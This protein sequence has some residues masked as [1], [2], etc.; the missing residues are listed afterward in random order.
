VADWYAYGFILQAG[1]ITWH[2][3]IQNRFTL[4]ASCRLRINIGSVLLFI[5]LLFYPFIAFISGRSWMQFEMFAL[6]PDP[7]V[8]ATLAILLI[9]KV[10]KFLYVIPII[11]VLISVTTL[12][13]M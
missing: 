7:T 3:V 10:P 6:A 11:W 1:L 9:Y 2:G 4:F 12:F 8:L 13:V 5:A